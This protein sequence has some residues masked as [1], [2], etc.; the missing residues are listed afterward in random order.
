MKRLMVSSVVVHD[1]FGL[2]HKNY[3]LKPENIGI[4]DKSPGCF[5]HPSLSGVFYDEVETFVTICK[6]GLLH[7]IQTDRK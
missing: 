7:H 4:S 1:S 2:G 5:C 3:P 6:P